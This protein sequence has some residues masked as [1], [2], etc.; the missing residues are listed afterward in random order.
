MP[1]IC[2]NC[3]GDDYL[4]HID[5]DHTITRCD[6]CQRTNTTCI[7]DVTLSEL[8]RPIVDLYEPVEE[9][10]PMEEMR[11]LAGDGDSI[12]E[13]IQQEW[14]LFPEIDYESLED[15]FR[16]MYS[17]EDEIPTFLTSYVEN[18]REYYGMH[19]EA[20]DQLKQEWDNFCNEII[21]SN[22]FFPQKTVDVDIL[23]ALLACLE[24]RLGNGKEFFR[25]RISETGKAFK[26]KD[27]GMPPADK[28]KSGRA[29]PVGIPYFYLASTSVTAIAEVRPSVT[30]VVSVGCFRIK[31]PL[32]IVDLADFP[33]IS[34]FR[35][36]DE[37]GKITLYLG[38]LKILSEE[39]SKPINPRKAELEY[40][41]LQYLCEF[42]KTLG[43]DG[44]GFK[45]S[46]GDGYNLLTFKQTNFSGKR[47]VSTVTIDGVRYSH[48]PL[49][50]H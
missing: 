8:L 17:E 19:Y 16:I 29:N 35:F 40:I 25:A 27:I 30:D 49:E 4:K 1:F 50:N 37:I 2:L 26:I 11:E 31:K 33:E 47:S 28:S 18:E 46:I 20:S 15:L 9:F 38:F 22:R 44:L 32:K 5:I 3:I 48:N 41:P 14:D 6:F 45:S 42:I 13:K 7:S 23:K 39:I 36:G 12:W 21:K 43:Y 24:K 34:P 10:M